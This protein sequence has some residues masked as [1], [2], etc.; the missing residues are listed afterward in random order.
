MK[1]IEN[2]I[3]KMMPAMN[4][5]SE[6]KYLQAISRSMMATLSIT[7]I[8]SISVLLIVFPIEDVTIFLNNFGLIE[9]LAAVNQ[10]TLGSQAIYISFLVSKNLVQLFIHQVY[11]S[12]AGVASV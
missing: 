2:Y 5:I 7:I 1:N 8:G 6:N 10:F 12:M 9:P 11:G 3:N 4:K